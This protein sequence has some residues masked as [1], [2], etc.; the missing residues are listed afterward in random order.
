MEKTAAQGAD[1]HKDIP[2]KKTLAEATEQLTIND[3][4]KLEQVNMN[5]EVESATDI[6]ADAQAV[7]EKYCK[8]SLGAG[9]IPIPALDLVALT[10]VQLKMVSE[11]AVIYGESFSEN[12]IK[13]IVT[14]ILGATLPQAVTIGGASS[15]VKSIPVIGTLVGMATMPLASAAATYAVG[16]TFIGHFEGGGTLLSINLKDMKKNVT[17]KAKQYKSKGKKE[18]TKG[19]EAVE[20]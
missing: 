3:S 9:F 13:S 20:A 17:E 10:G 4:T 1:K 19:E 15:M 7:V 14:P 11:I 16:S 18:D 12:R 2:Q 5:T 6:K 8:W